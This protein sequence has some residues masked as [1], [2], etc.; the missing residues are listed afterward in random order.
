MHVGLVRHSKQ[1]MSYPKPKRIKNRK[2]LDSF[3]DKACVINNY[4][5]SG[6]VSGHHIQSKGAGGPDVAE[7]ILALCHWHH[8]EIHK[9]GSSKF[10]EKYPDLKP[11]LVKK[12]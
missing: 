12:Y 2:L 9:I 7:N 8:V 4:G 1:T 3:H 11:R 10:I 5:C 6:Q